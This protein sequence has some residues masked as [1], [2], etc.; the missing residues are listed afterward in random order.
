MRYKVFINGK[1]AGKVTAKDQEKAIEKAEKENK[2]FML[3][4]IKN[5][6]KGQTA[7]TKAKKIDKAV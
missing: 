3:L 7:Y 4:V 1:L 5:I 2:N 6:L